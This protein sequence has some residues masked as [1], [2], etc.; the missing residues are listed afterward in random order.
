MPSLAAVP[1]VQERLDIPVMTASIA[2][3]WRTLRALGLP[4]VAPHAGAL[5]G[6]AYA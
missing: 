2:T 1:V 3:T 6:G 4:A 5:L